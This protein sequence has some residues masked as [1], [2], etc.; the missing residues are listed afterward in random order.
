MH[1]DEEPLLSMLTRPLFAFGSG[2]LLTGAVLSF[3]C[4]VGTYGVRAI[5]NQWLSNL[6]LD[7][8]DRR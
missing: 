2:C 1:E 4:M 7:P 3:T 5:A 6:S 8:S